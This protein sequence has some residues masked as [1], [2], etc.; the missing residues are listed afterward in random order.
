MA[1][2]S[3]AEITVWQL[4]S[5]NLSVWSQDK[6]QECI[7]EESLENGRIWTV[8][9]QT[10]QSW[11]RCYKGVTLLH[12]DNICYLCSCISVPVSCHQLRYTSFNR[13]IIFLIVLVLL[14]PAFIQ[15][16]QATEFP[17]PPCSSHVLQHDSASLCTKAHTNHSIE[18]SVFQWWVRLLLEQEALSINCIYRTSFSLESSKTFLV[19]CT[20]HL[21]NAGILETEIG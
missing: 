1:L 4:F 5:W 17:W 21:W 3:E 18:L 9:Q 6:I 12:P 13:K 16:E 14:P 15:F 7:E 11:L 19:I 20:S 8:G 2:F 10:A